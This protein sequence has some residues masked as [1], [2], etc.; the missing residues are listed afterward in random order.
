M[1][2]A[3]ANS[4]TRHDAGSA[5]CQ[6][7]SSRA[8]SLGGPGTDRDMFGRQANILPCRIEL[9]GPRWCSGGG[10]EK[11]GGTH[12]SAGAIHPGTTIG[13]VHL[14]VRDLERSVRFY[15]ERL[16]FRVHR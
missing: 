7:Q 4:S 1:R 3:K 5:T 16:G 10:T 12:M 2:A 15:E 8:S 6:P 13:A 9:R 11:S 14:T